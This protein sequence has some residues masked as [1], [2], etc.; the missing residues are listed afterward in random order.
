[1]GVGLVA[2]QG[3]PFEAAVLRREVLDNEDAV[4]G[5]DTVA[6][7]ECRWGEEGYERVQYFLVVPQLKPAGQVVQVDKE[8]DDSDSQ[9]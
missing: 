3:G 6:G 7:Q 1:L 9:T 2:D 5:G 8:E 4:V